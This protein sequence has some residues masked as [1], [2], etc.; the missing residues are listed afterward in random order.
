MPVLAKIIKYYFINFYSSLLNSNLVALI[1]TEFF[2]WNSYLQGSLDPSMLF[3]T[4]LCLI[5]LIDGEAL[6]GV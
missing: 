2:L 4:N 1:A 3:A 6:V 5:D